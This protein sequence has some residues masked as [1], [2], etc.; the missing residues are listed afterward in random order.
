[1]DRLM[2][3]HDQLASYLEDVDEALGPSEVG[4]LSGSAILITGAHGL[5]GSSLTDVCLRNG[6]TVYAAGRSLEG[7]RRR[8]SYVAG[9]VHLRLVPFDADKPFDFDEPVDYIVHAAANA[10]PALFSTS[11]FETMRF[12]FEGTARMLDLSSRL[13]A[14]LLYISSS[15]VYG[16]NDMGRPYSEKDYGFVD[17]LNPRACYPSSKRA[18]ETMCSAHS[19]E[20][21]TDF[22]VARPGHV[23]G[24]MST[25]SD[26]R[27]AA[28]F[29]R[30]A[31]LGEDIVLKSDGRSLR[32]YLC[33]LDCATALLTILVRG[34]A[35][36]AYN[37]AGERAVSIR[38]LA[39]DFAAASG[40][41]LIYERP[42][43]A[44]AA[45][46]NLMDNSALDGTKLLG[47]GWKP[48][49]SVEEAVSRT[50]SQLSLFES[51][52]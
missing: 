10:H 39:G 43:G 15:E 11:P 51:L 8:F 1:M 20:H 18:A 21:G 23:F 29:A 22:V 14:R 37:V 49:F 33:A 16:R 3:P 41:N 50:V 12:A 45:S 40:R 42:T 46:F 5:V 31:A 27:A 17:I 19:V 47:L 48:S 44:E 38:E 24:P 52:V 6:M 28:Q 2:T 26:S 30:K 25:A 32:S 13:G 36:E 7:L 35:G 4:G 34:A 9:G